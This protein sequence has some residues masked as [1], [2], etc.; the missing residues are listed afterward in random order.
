MSVQNRAFHAGLDRMSGLQTAR[1]AIQVLE[2]DI[3]TAGTNVPAGQ[4]PVIAAHRD[5][6]SFSA[7]YVTNISDDPFAVFYDPDAPSG[8]VTMTTT[9]KQVGPP[10]GF[11]FP[12]T[13]Y[14]LGPAIS[15]AEMITFYYVADTSTTRSDDYVLYRKV[16]HNTPEVVARN[17]LR[18]AG[19]FFKYF[20]DNG[21]TVDTFTSSQLPVYHS[22]RLHRGALD[23][24]AV[25]KIDS[26]RGVRVTVRATNGLTGA[27]EEIVELSRVIPIKNVA[28]EVVEACGSRPILGQALNR[29]LVDQGGGKYAVNLTWNRGTDESGGESDVMRYVIW[30]RGPGASTWDEPFLSIPAGEPTYTYLDETVENDSVYTYGLAAQ[31]CTP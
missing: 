5:M 24:G 20:K 4:P 27:N 15:P 16:N 12:D 6:F 19:Q 26:I 11:E 31:D 25:S 29:T 14:R 30:R 28:I 22:R 7:D 3:S 21:I 2:E 1:F 9:K 23:T 18:P 13:T 10:S 17:L 8:Q